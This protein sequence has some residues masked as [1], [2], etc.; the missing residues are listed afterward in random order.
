[1]TLPSPPPVSQWSLIPLFM[2][3]LSSLGAVMG[4]ATA[5]AMRDPLQS[6][7]HLVS[8]WHVATGRHQDTDGVLDEHSRTP[9]AWRVYHHHATD[10]GQAEIVEYDLFDGDGRPLWREHPVHGRNVDV[11][12]LP[13]HT[14]APIRT[15]AFPWDPREPRIAYGV[16][17]PVF[18][19]GHPVGHEPLRDGP[20]PIWSRGSIASEP[21]IDINA[22]PLML[23]DARARM[24]Q[25]GAPV[26]LYSS[27]AET[28]VFVNGSIAMDGRD[29]GEW[30]GVYS[31]RTDSQSDLGR[32]WRADAVKEVIRSEVRP[33]G[34]WGE[35]VHRT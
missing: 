29:Y 24:G 3:L 22:L 19:T 18:I 21:A 2:E 31:G 17:S 27:G 32:V 10:L 25:S 7:T 28:T 34:P 26:L 6:H 15:F 9:S 4:R 8:C 14:N 23:V 30:L 12:A 20:F 5:F 35:P 11:V 33:L 1:M 13:I 16:G